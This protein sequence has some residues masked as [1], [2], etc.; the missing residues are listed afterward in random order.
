MGPITHQIWKIN[1][2]TKIKWNTENWKQEVLSKSILKW[3]R[4]AKLYI[5]YDE[6]YNNSK[7]SEYLAK[8]RMNSLQLEEYF[9]RGKREIHDATY[10]LCGI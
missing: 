4:E 2:N 10:P 3:Y 5:G 1:K 6:C 8:A 7:A 9:R